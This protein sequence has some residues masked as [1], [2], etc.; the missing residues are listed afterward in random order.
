MFLSNF[1]PKIRWV[2][3]FQKTTLYTY[4]TA[5]CGLTLMVYGTSLDR[6]RSRTKLSKVQ[7]K[8][9][10]NFNGILLAQVVLLLF[11]GFFNFCT[12]A[13]NTLPRNY[14]MCKRFYINKQI[15]QLNILKSSYFGYN[16]LVFKVRVKICDL[17]T[18]VLYK[19]KLWSFNTFKETCFKHLNKLKTY[20]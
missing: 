2:A 17:K 19:K 15:I 3:S 5:L 12:I 13:L 9:Y 14:P 11:Y 1:N 20:C 8:Y 18:W 6:I 4:N 7:W 10:V 16:K